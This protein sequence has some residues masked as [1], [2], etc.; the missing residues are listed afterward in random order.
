MKVL[1]INNV[2]YRRGGADAVYLNTADLLMKHGN[3][4]V[5]FNMRKDNNL[6]CKDEKYWVSS[7]ESR[8]KGIKSTLL[9]LRNFFCNPEAAE[10]IEELILAEKPDIVH[11]HL[12]WGC[13]ISPSITKVLK[14]YQIPLVQTVHDY[15]MICPIA[16]LM[17]KKGSVC[18]RCKGK[19]FYKAGLYNC[20]HHGRVRSILMAAE[21]YYHN[22]FFYP[23]EVVDGFVFVSNFAYK[24]H[25][26]YM[27]R[28]KDANVTVLY[29]FTVSDGD[30][31]QNS[32]EKYIL[33][34]GRLSYEKGIRT[35]LEA[36]ESYPEMAVRVVGTGPIEEELKKNYINTCASG[37][38]SEAKKCYENIHFLGYHSG[39]TLKELVRNAQFVCVPS[40]CYENNPMTIVEAYSMGTPVIGARIGGIPEIIEEGKTGYCFES[41]NVEDLYKVIKKA[42]MMAEND[43][44]DMRQNAFTFYLNNFSPELHYEKL[45][46]FYKHTLEI[47]E[48]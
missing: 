8:P 16:L 12:F 33:Y 3:D 1:Q 43:Y 7:I 34:Y 32:K 22:K 2:H 37:S 13:G 45:M 17:D 46:S 6:P 42:T 39:G 31:S 35:L 21:M 36:M 20:S 29:N 24:K 25:L 4:V 41:G 18:E 38:I 15:R 44:L 48:R 5:F 19:F 23:T 40:E 14:K 30:Y 28:L 11:I 27:P 26:Q 47:Y 9:E 10:K